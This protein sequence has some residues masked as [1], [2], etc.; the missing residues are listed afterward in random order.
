MRP[1]IIFALAFVAGGCA[2][3]APP[4]SLE[5][6]RTVR[7][8]AA[9]VADTTVTAFVTAIDADTVTFLAEGSGE[10]RLWLQDVSSLEVWNGRKRN[11]RGGALVGLLIGAGLGFFGGSA[12]D[13]QEGTGASGYLILGAI[14]GGLGALVGSAIG[15]AFESDR[16]DRVIP[17]ARRPSRPRRQMARPHGAAPSWLTRPCAG[18]CREF[19]PPAVRP[20]TRESPTRR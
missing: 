10:H 20:Q 19:R 4:A 2:T 12:L 3:S 11:T 17:A 14:Y 13:Y 15:S 1:P 9:S 7:F 5:I 8:T 16:W 6:G 18:A